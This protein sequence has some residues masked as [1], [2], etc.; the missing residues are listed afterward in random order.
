[1]GKKELNIV[2]KQNGYLLLL[3]LLFVFSSRMKSAAQ[4]FTIDTIAA[5]IRNYVDT[6]PEITVYGKRIDRNAK[7]ITY[8]SFSKGNYFREGKVYIGA[9]Y[10]KIGTTD[11]FPFCVPINN[12]KGFEIQIDSIFIKG[13]KLQS[14]K[15]ILL[16]NLYK[17]NKLYETQS[18]SETYYRKNKTNVFIF[19]SGFRLPK[20][21][22]YLAFNYRFSKMPFDFY[23]KT[24]THIKG[25][26]YSYN[27]ERN[28][29]QLTPAADEVSIYTPQIKIFCSITE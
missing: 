16:F 18:A 24:N 1:M 11:I 6:I 15:I 27:R 13:S 22:S 4:Q 28:D 2:S 8:S 9:S 5:S 21:E 25:T 29:F 17:D 19:D 26:V 3:L 7:I 20:G 14:P 23:V 10:L 12:E